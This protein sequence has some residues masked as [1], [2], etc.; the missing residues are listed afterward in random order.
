MI[1]ALTNA[2]PLPPKV[3]KAFNDLRKG[4]RRIRIAARMS[5]SEFASGTGLTAEQLDALEKGNLLPRPDLRDAWI[6][7]LRSVRQRLVSPA[8]APL[9]APASPLKSNARN[10]ARC[11]KL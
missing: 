2:S 5:L 4:A 1:A 11:K 7:R 9:S 6:A 3:R 8:A 10:L